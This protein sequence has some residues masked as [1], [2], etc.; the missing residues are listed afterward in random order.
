MSTGL[1]A[2]FPGA[3]GEGDDSDSDGFTNRDEWLAG[4]DPTQRGSR[5]E[6]ELAPRPAD[7][8]ASDKTPIEAGQ[9]G[10]YFRSVPGRYY[11]VQRAT[12]LGGAWELQAVRVADAIQT[13]FVLPKPDGQAF[14]RVLI[15][16]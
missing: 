10:V 9:H 3:S 11:G 8:S 1:T 2:Q 6:M 12:A 5:L 16:P 15:L 4:T 14:Y 7:L 13:R